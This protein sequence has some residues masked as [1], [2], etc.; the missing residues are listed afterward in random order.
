MEKDEDVFKTVFNQF[1]GTLLA[2]AKTMTSDYDLANDIV[3]N[4]FAILWEKH[5]NLLSDPSLKSYLFT[6]VHNSY[7][8]H[9]RKN[10]RKN[11]TLEDIKHEALRAGLNEDEGK[12]E[13]RIKK[14]RSTIDKLPFKCREILLMNK[15]DGL[16]YKEIADQLNISTKTVESQMR[17][18]FKKIREAFG[19][20]NFILFLLFRNFHRVNK[21]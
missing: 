19:A 3:Q 17:I 7:V 2:Y 16:K 6:A 1:Y 8:D 21:F 9:Y 14:L 15:R 10:K 11:K 4:N 5:R 12:T 20:D 13:Q 18:A